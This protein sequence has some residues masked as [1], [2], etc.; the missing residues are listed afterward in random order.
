MIRKPTSPKW[1]DGHAE[2]CF[3]NSHSPGSQG[4]VDL[5]LPHP[6]FPVSSGRWIAPFPSET[7]FTAIFLQFNKKFSRESFL[8]FFF[9]FL[10]VL[11]LVSGLKILSL[12]SKNEENENFSLKKKKRFFSEDEPQKGL[13]FFTLHD[14][15]S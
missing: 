5:K 15:Y 8:V 1:G 2:A 13:L 10:Y 3:Q 9:F 4:S 14:E 11:L 7:K 6:Q 12:K